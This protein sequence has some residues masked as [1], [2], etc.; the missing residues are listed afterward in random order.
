MLVLCL[1]FLIAFADQATKYLIKRNLPMLG[2]QVVVIPSFFNINHV[3]NTGAAWGVFAGFNG[4]LI[5]LSAVML[6]AIVIFRHHFVTGRVLHRIALGLMIGGIVGNLVDR[7]RLGYVVDFLEFYWK[8]YHFP[9]F[10]V[11]DSAICVG[12]GLYVLTQLL[13]DRKAAETA[14]PAG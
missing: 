10:N 4:W 7:V 1:S 13:G 5:L 9:S 8:G 14:A 3:H 11:A 2:D 12:V 6:A